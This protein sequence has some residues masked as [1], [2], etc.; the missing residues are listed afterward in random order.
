MSYSVIVGNI[1]MVHEGDDEAGAVAVFDHYVRLSKMGNGRAGGEE[2]VMWEN[3]EPTREYSPPEE[4]DMVQRLIEEDTPLFS[5]HRW[6]A[7]QL[8]ERI[9]MVA[10]NGQLGFPR[11]DYRGWEYKHTVHSLSEAVEKIIEIYTGL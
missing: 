8:E 5:A 6:K 9:V 11:E 4:E 3:G 1:G 7:Y 2:V 10:F